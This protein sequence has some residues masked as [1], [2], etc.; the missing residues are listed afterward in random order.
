MGEY[1]GLLYLNSDHAQE[2]ADV[3]N[4]VRPENA[5]T[6]YALTS[7]VVTE[8]GP[9]RFM[10]EWQ[11]VEVPLPDIKIGPAGSRIRQ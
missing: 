4:E 6:F 3:L 1:N 7:N 5:T 10:P 11:P 8:P 9:T 2:A